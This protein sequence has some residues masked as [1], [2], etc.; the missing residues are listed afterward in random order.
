MEHLGVLML[1]HHTLKER[2]SSLGKLREGEFSFTAPWNESFRDEK[3]GGPFPFL[4]ESRLVQ[5]ADLFGDF[6]VKDPVCK[7]GE[8]AASLSLT[9]VF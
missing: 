2:I 4:A 1:A 7:V 9:M 3:R 5:L 6:E 8:K